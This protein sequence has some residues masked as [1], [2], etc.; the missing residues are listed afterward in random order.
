MKLL[1]V[2]RL[3]NYYLFI[4]TFDYLDYGFISKLNKIIKFK[5]FKFKVDIFSS[6]TNNFINLYVQSLN[7]EWNCIQRF[8]LKFKHSM[9]NNQ[10][11]FLQNTIRGHRLY[12]F[13][14]HCL[15]SIFIDKLVI[16]VKGKSNYRIQIL[17][18]TQWN[19]FRCNFFISDY[20]FHNNELLVNLIFIN[21]TNKEFVLNKQFIRLNLL[22]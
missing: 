20:F 9:H 7:L 19:K 15:N 16:E 1:L 14:D 6:H 22:P 10:V 18:R 4:N 21:F 8:F 2:P 17:N 3:Q 11:K 13:L 5:S 12:E